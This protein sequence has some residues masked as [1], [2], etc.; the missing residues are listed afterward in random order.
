MSDENKS[1][2]NVLEVMDA[3]ISCLECNSADK[4]ASELRE[5]RSAM[6]ELIEGAWMLIEAESPK[7]CFQNRMEND[8][9]KV[10]RSALG[11]VGGAS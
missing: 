4:Y 5:A 9:R 1:S 3:S 6:A 2:T 8:A 11:R 7:Q 10:I